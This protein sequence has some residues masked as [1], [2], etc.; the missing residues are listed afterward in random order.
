MFIPTFCYAEH[1]KMFL[2]LWALLMCLWTAVSIAALDSAHTE[3]DSNPI[4][5]NIHERR[6]CHEDWDTSDMGEA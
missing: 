4:G 1:L 2:K 3:P 6:F 5:V